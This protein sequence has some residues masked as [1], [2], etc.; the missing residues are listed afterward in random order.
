MTN[1]L[2]VPGPST[3]AVHAGASGTHAHNAIV[4]PVVQSATYTFADTQDLT[5]HQQATLLGQAGDRVDYGRYGNA[6]V[7]EVER[8]L[9]ALEGS[10]ECVLFASGMAA[11]TTTLLA[12]LGAGAHILI[13]D[14]SYR[15]TRQFCLTFLNRYGVETSVVAAADASL[16]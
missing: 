6:T 10:A 8:R 12:L 1:P 16:G 2:A 9:A 14:D 7:M 4:Q 13:T 5:A 3:R 11:V 15:R